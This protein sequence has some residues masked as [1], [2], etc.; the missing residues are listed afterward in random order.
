M[1]GV[2]IIRVLSGF[3]G[4]F[5]VPSLACAVWAF[6][7]DRYEQASLFILVV[8]A[9]VVMGAAF[10]IATQKK[11][12][13]PAQA[14]DIVGFLML[15]WLVL[16]V[17]GAVPFLLVS[18]GRLGLAFFEAASSATTTGTSLL[19]E[20]V[21][22]PASL[23]AWKGLL[24]LFGATLSVTGVLIVVN[25]IGAS[26]PGLGASIPVRFNTEFGLSGFN[27]TFLAIGFVFATMTIVLNIGLLIAGNGLRESFALAI[28]AATTGQVMS[29]EA[30]GHSLSTTS[31]LIMVVGLIFGSLNVVLIYNIIRKPL[32][33]LTDRETASI[34]VLILVMTILLSLQVNVER[35]LVDAITASV[36][37]ISTS[38]ILLSDIDVFGIPSAILLFFGFIGG[39]A[40]SATGGIKIYRMLVLASRSGHEFERLAQ[41]HAV[42]RFEHGGERFSVRAVLTVWAY[43]VAFAIISVTISGALALLGADFQEAMLTA[44]GAITNSAALITTD[45]IAGSPLIGVTE[46]LLAFSLILGRLELLLLL[47]LLSGE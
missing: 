23:L 21:P 35:D 14:R 31:K 19:A 18:D 43:L 16:C 40:I 39:A 37:V 44:L 29:A 28:S 1:D 11:K 36:S 7:N 13:E 20:S 2:I 34:L 22:I 8:T 24:H 38:G 6:Q 10:A 15:A 33:L 3:L 46:I 27:K 41:P 45:W 9:S 32:R 12:T 30:L 26:L 25:K 17:L 5:S 42:A 47:A 4:A